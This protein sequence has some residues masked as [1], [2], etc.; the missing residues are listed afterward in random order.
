MHH[1]EPWALGERAVGVMPNSGGQ[2]M[3][4]GRKTSKTQGER[5]TV[6]EKGTKLTRK[7]KE[8]KEHKK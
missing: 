3:T 8:K 1:D 7:A 5:E 4:G 2:M 6:S